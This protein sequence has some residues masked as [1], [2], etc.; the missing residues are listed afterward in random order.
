MLAAVALLVFV[1][2]PGDGDGVPSLAA[3]DALR[4]ASLQHLEFEA[5]RVRLFAGET[6]MPIAPGARLPSDRTELRLSLEAGAR[7]RVS[8]D[9]A[10][11]W[12]EGPLEV[13]SDSRERWNLRLNGLGRARVDAREVF[14]RVELP[15]TARVDAS[16]GLAWLEGSPDGSWRAG[17]DAG[18]PMM[19]GPPQGARWPGLRSLAAGE[20]VRLMPARVTPPPSAAAS[21]PSATPAW[22]SFAWPWSPQSPSSARAA[23]VP[24]PAAPTDAADEPF[25]VGALREL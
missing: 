4:G 5:G 18:A 13:E 12:L 24:A 16:R 2:I 8:I 14:V 3:A 21:A 9:G 10:A 22:G 7:M 19:I 6:W 1:A 11:V 20:R 17:N 25:F 15:G 23:A